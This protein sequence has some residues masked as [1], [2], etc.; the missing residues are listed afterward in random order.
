MTKR[1]VILFMFKWKYTIVGYF[2]FVVLLVTTLVY[3]LPKKYEV[4][5]SVLVESNRAP[6]MRAAIALGTDELTMLNSAVAIIGSKPVIRGAAEKVGLFDGGEEPSAVEL[7]VDGVKAWMEEVGLKEEKTSMDALVEDLEDNLKIEPLAASNVISLTLK[8]KNPQWIAEIVNAVTDSYIDNHLRIFSSKGT[9]EVFRLQVERLSNELGTR[10]EKLAN[11]KSRESVTALSETRQQLVLRLGELKTRLSG[12]REE[13]AE[14][15]MRFSP[16]HDKLVL[17][18]DKIANSRRHMG[19]VQA[20]LNDLERKD[21]VIKKLEDDIKTAERSYSDYQ[22]RYEEEQ[23]RNMANADVVNVRVIAYAIPPA[24]A[25]HSRIFY[26]FLSVIGG[27]F[28]S[29]SIALIKEYFDHRISSGADVSEIL[30]VP[31]LGSVGRARL[32]F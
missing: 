17:V 25:K 8:G 12:E 18:E 1:D 31:T 23:L 2:L 27:L 13:L 30:G 20:E 28:F 6:V 3:L 11:Y 10:R 15:A 16:G 21:A 5:S 4:S 29:I 7:F 32:P 19:E 9:S 24:N 26:I 22:K 14:V